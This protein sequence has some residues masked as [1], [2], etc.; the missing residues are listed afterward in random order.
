MT[1]KKRQ[2]T[3]QPEQSQG[4]NSPAEEEVDLINLLKFLARKKVII[5]AVTSLCALF[6][7]FYAQSITPIYRATVG[8]IG[9][10]DSFP[11][12]S[13]AANRLLLGQVITKQLAVKPEDIFNRFLYHIKSSELRQEVFVNGGFQKKFSRKLAPATTLNMPRWLTLPGFDKRRG[14]GVDTDQSIAPINSIQLIA[15]QNQRT[16]SLKLEGSQ[17]K[18]MLEFLMALAKAAK[19]NVYIKLNDRI[20]AGIKSRIIKLSM[21]LDIA[22]SMGI[23]NN[24]FGKTTVNAPFWFRYGELALQQEIKSLKSAEEIFKTKN[25]SSADL[26]LLKFKAVTVYK[27]SYAL[28]K[29][30]QSWV[31][32]GLG[33]IFGLFISIVMIFLID[34]KQLKAKE[35]PSAS[36]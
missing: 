3:V 21:Q 19:E 22:K 28:A 24:S 35:T 6:S 13:S 20:H 27:D 33:V 36:T 5:L 10:M 30:Y 2:S 9:T 14:T 11:P 34:R 4:V 31:I 25:L 23:K 12:S 15:D 16:V 32:V 7:M 26:P 17:P 8:F 1:E 18:V 29:P